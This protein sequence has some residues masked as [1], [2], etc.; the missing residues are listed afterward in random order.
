[1][2]E[3]KKTEKEKEENIWRRIHFLLRR[4]KTEKEKEENIRRARS[5]KD[6]VSAGA[7][8]HFRSTDLLMTQPPLKAEKYWRTENI[9]SKQS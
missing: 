5:S 4:R 1:M 7:N 2:E 9:C 6:E 8:N 3:K